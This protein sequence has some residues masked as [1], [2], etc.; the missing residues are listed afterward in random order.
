MEALPPLTLI[1][2]LCEVLDSDKISYCHWKSNA[3]LDRSAS[4][5]NDLDLLINR[6][7]LQ[8]FREIL[9][10]LGFKECLVDKIKQLPGVQDFLGYDAPADK[11]V[12]VHAHFQLILGHD[13]S[14][15][16]HLPVEKAYLE[17]VRQC[18]ILKIPA[19]EF[20]LVI[21][22]IRMIIKHST[23][24]TILNR[25][26]KLSRTEEQERIYLETNAD[27]AKVSG[28][29]QQYLPFIDNELFDECLGALRPGCPLMRRIRAGWRL[30][31]RLDAHTRHSQ[32]A[33]LFIKLWQRVYFIFKWRVL[34]QR[35][36][37]RLANGGAMIAIVGGDGAGKTTTVEELFTWL[38]HSFDVTKI[39]L[40]KPTWSLPTIFVR[41]LLKVGRS[42]GLYPFMK[43]PIEYT[44]DEKSLVFPGYPWLIR[45]V[46]TARDRYLTYVK[47][48][49]FANNGGLV[50]S[51]RFPLSHIKLMDG[52]QASRM[53]SNYPTNRFL[54]FMIEI[55]EEYYESIL[56]PEI[57]VVLKVDPETAVRRKVDEDAISV[58][59]RSKEIW[60]IDWC[61]IPASVID[62]NQPKEKVLS[63]LKK[64][65]WSSL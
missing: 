62:A 27:P 54:K 9:F 57:L 32:I 2:Q 64:L 4:G 11:Y 30:Q 43:A 21:F 52:P 40:G 13:L 63:D 36:E 6:S 47:A 19:P 7:D 51:D 10:R 58:Q 48:R 22:V 28:I 3:A 33:N 46:C 44:T 24:D 5:E 23:W 16:Y 18:G 26:G 14:K 49:R 31:S 41:G 38:S 56:L 25:E 59:A 20:E 8:R 15:N 45:E 29:L 65:V 50:I 39:H 37:F 1:A 35:Y 42:L 17:S 61:N 53:T 55:E 34:K 60:D 12:H